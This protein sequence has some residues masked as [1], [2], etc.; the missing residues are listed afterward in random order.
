M[1][2]LSKT[3]LSIGQL[4]KE[5]LFTRAYF[6]EVKMFVLLGQISLDICNLGLLSP[7]TSVSMKNVSTMLDC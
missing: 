6:K 1:G 5:S 3:K 2:E 7:W 4:F